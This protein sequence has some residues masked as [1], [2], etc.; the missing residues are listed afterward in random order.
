[1]E[2]P[3][4]LARDLP[5]CLYQVAAPPAVVTAAL[6]DGARFETVVIG[7]GY[8]GLSTALH[9]AERGRSVAVLEAREPGWG[10]AGRNGGQVNA[11]V[12]Q[13]PETVMRELGPVYGP[14][15]VR[16]SL[17][18]PDLL[19]KLIE[20]LGIDCGA[21]RCGTLRAAYSGAHLAA[22]QAAAEQWRAHGSAVELWS[23]ERMA[24]ETGTSRY[25]A[26]MFDPRGGAVQPLALARGLAAAAQRAGASI[27]SLTPVVGL[28]RQGTEWRV[29]TPT[30]MVRASQVVIATQAYSDGL[31]P[32]LRTSF[33]P[34][35]S[36]IIATEPMP[37]EIAASVL[38]GRQVVYEV[39][40]IVMY[41]RRDAANR[42]LMGGRGVQRTAVDPSDFRHLTRY[43]R[44]LWPA[45]D[46][47]RW[48]HWWNGQLAMTLD[49]NPRFHIPAPGLYIML[50]YAR[51]V[52]LA[53]A[54]GAELASVVAGAPP[55]T[56]PLPVSPIRSIPLHRFW[57]LGVAARVLQGRLLDSIGRRH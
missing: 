46:G 10:A 37:D 39:G 52:A 53:A 23:Q 12:K 31:W 35:F 54:F 30:A 3:T 43:A 24:A 19:F 40:N 44:R 29:R 22:L 7:G 17:E 27:H 9:L 16:L 33:V 56:F 49:F 47:I 13:E 5:S 20:R 38:P 2:T 26:G 21:A 51:G 6:A 36:S 18:G 48:T 1:M 42:L 50:G 14:R 4:P 25:T 41:F 8:T 55:E 11:G 15:L 28:E 57:R 34:A 45:L 32:G